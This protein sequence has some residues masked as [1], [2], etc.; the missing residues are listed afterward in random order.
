M[1]P[2]HSW[3]FGV[4]VSKPDWWSGGPWIKPHNNLFHIAK[5]FVIQLDELDEFYIQN[6]KKSIVVNVNVI[7]SVITGLTVRW[8]RIGPPKISH[9]CYHCATS[10]PNGSGS[11]WLIPTEDLGDSRLTFIGPMWKAKFEHVFPGNSSHRVQWWWSCAICLKILWII[12]HFFLI[13]CYF[14]SFCSD[15]VKILRDNNDSDL[16]QIYL[17]RYAFPRGSIY[18]VLPQNSFG[19]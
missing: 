10:S 8:R 18:L 4:V 7:P 1:S 11:G 12:I 5:F 15:D 6:R 16:W 2:T 17:S 13:R 14:I 9:S 3:H 19:N